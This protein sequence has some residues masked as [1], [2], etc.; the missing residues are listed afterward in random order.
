MRSNDNFYR[1]LIEQAHHLLTTHEFGSSAVRHEKLRE[2][3]YLLDAHEA[4]R[5]VVLAKLAYVPANYDA[6]FVSRLRH[7]LRDRFPDRIAG[8]L[9]IS[10]GY[11]LIGEVGR[12]FRP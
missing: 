12:D 10:G 8:L 11:Y 2:T 7:H 3:A 6:A 1:D 5:D 9:N 4:G